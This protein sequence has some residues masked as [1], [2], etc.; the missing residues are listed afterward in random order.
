MKFPHI[1]LLSLTL[2]TAFEAYA[3]DPALD[4]AIAD[5]GHRWA[6]IYYQMPDKQKDDAYSELLTRL[7]QLA[8]EHPKD[9]EPIVWQAIVL[10][11]A[12]KV[13]GGLSA[14]R[15]AKDARELLISAEAIEPTVMN[16]SIYGSLGSL[17]AKVPGWPLGFGDKKQAQIYFEKALAIDADSIDTN[18]FY[19][20]YLADTGDYAKAMQ[21]LQ[22]AIAAP[23]RAGR[24]DADAGRRQEAQTLLDAVKKKS[25]AS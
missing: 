3:A 2:T 9:A 19:A 24:E 5:A 14:L 7:Q 4:Q 10:S 13:E 12:A 20:D 17:Y 21:Y 23:P 25:G 16:G 11:S 8:H 6:A 15:K 18:F 22:R 1:F